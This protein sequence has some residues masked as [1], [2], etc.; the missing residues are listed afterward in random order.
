MYIVL[1]L[2]RSSYCPSEQRLLAQREYHLS[3]SLE[4][5]VSRVTWLSALPFVALARRLRWA[6]AH[7]SAASA[8]AL[9]WEH[10]GSLQ[11]RK[12]LLSLA[13]YVL[14]TLQPL[15][16]LSQLLP[17]PQTVDKGWLMCWLFAACLSLLLFPSFFFT[18]IHFFFLS[19]NFLFSPFFEG[20]QTLPSRPRGIFPAVSIRR[21]LMAWSALP[22]PLWFSLHEFPTPLIF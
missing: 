20:C 1:P 12:P 3:H 21:G 11:C 7:L 8:L 10:P 9:P 4:K 14:Q 22:S 15:L 2:P 16:L 19:Y 13:L 18:F 5:P 17:H 6:C